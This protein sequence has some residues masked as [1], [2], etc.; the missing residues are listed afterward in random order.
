MTKGIYLLLGSNMGDKRLQLVTTIQKICRT[1]EILK[2]SS[3]YETAAWGNTNQPSFY[4]QVIQIA[5][6]FDPIYLLS[7]L[8]KIEEEMGRVREDKWGQRIIDIDILYYDDRIIETDNLSI[9]H[10]EIQNRRFTLVPLVEIAAEYQ[11][12][13][14]KKNQKELMDDCEDDLAV[15]LID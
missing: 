10:S 4:N 1:C 2:Q 15:F 12:P 5:T 3:I 8:L 13:I 11:H 6:S 7:I 14:L 9:P